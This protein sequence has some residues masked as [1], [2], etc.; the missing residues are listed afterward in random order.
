LGKALSGSVVGCVG[1]MFGGHVLG[2]ENLMDR[3]GGKEER[4]RLR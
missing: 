4:V 3:L 2:F 1:G